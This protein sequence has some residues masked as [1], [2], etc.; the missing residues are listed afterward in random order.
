[1][2]PRVLGHHFH[3][4]ARRHFANARHEQEQAVPAHLV[5]R[6]LEDAEKGEHVL[7]VRGLE[8]LETAPLVEGDVA[9]RELDLEIGAVVARA[10]QHRDLS[11]RCP[12]FVQLEDPVTN[13]VC[14]GS[15]CA[16]TSQGRSPP[17]RRV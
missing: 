9:G 4:V 17:V 14:V 13:R 15:S 16:V 3:R 11:Q 1:M 8:E 2:A 5:A 7:D 6:I 12:L 10:E